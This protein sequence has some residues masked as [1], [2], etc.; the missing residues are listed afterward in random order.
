[1]SQG[2]IEAL[3]KVRRQMRKDTLKNNNS[4]KYSDGA[5]ISKGRKCVIPNV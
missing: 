2:R 4:Q 3:P 5:C 1:M